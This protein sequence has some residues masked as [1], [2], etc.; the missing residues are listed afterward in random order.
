MYHH[1]IGNLIF[2][3]L[4][5]HDYVFCEKSTKIGMHESKLF[6][7]FPF[8]VVTSRPFVVHQVCNI[9]NKTILKCRSEAASPSI[10]NKF[11]PGF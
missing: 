10:V 8:F 5:T 7:S 1:F 6:H 11:T 2:T 9:S 4:R 3:N